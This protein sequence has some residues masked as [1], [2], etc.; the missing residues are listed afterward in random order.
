[1]T[2][3]SCVPLALGASA[4]FALTSA[5]QHRSAATEQLHRVGDPRLLLRLLRRPLW[6]SSLLSN[7]AAVA[8]QVLALRAGTL[9][10]VQSL[11]VSSIIL[12]LPCEAA[13]NGRS[14]Q[15]RELVGAG[16]GTVG[17]GVFVLAARPAAGITSPAPTVWALILLASAGVVVASILG[18]RVSVGLARPVLLGLATG[19][20][21]GVATALFK[22]CSHQVTHPALLLGNWPVYVLVLV[23]I[24]GVVL[25][26]NVYQS[27]VLAPGL[28]ALTLAEPLT[29]L[30][31][32]TTAFEERLSL[33][34]LNAG[35]L[36]VAVVMAATGLWLITTTGLPAARGHS[37]AGS[38]D[39]RAG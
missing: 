5:L 7:G 18:A 27:G 20:V 9:V 29:A 3:W 32:G 26:Q 22:A 23:G 6:L 14:L 13:L 10:V 4:L 17:I 39:D 2:S 12:A 38:L 19:V 28:T 34:L 31:I 16:L 36:V 1:M 33:H 11:I 30:A 37:P 25:N 21:Y 8:L 35:A 24:L 15:R